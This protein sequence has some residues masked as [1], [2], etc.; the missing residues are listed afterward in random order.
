MRESD[1]RRSDPHSTQ[2]R[3]QHVLR[4]DRG[5]NSIDVLQTIVDALKD[6]ADT[7]IY[8]G[9]EIPDTDDIGITVILED[10]PRPQSSNHM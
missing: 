8:R 4:A 9:E 7:M 6:D 1:T 3:Y 2:T 5:Q 10:T